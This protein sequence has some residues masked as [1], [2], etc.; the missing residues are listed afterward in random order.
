MI[1]VEFH[2]D[3][4]KLQELLK[5]K[6]DSEEIERLKDQVENLTKQRDSA[7]ERKR[8]ASNEAHRQAKKV[9][10]LKAEIKKL[11]SQEYDACDDSGFKAGDVVEVADILNYKA[12]LKGHKFVIRHIDP[13]G[14]VEL[15]G[16]DGSRYNPECFKKIGHV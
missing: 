9:K 1:T 6:G 12:L 2:I 16:H 10:E 5:S 8:I 15:Y 13:W 14:G 7:W 3:E 4:D 11:R